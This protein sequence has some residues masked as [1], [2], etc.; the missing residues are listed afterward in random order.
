MVAL[1]ISPPRSKFRLAIAVAVL[2]ICAITTASGQT[3]NTVPDAQK[4]PAAQSA[5]A[6]SDQVFDS[7]YRRFYDTYRLGPADEIS[8]R[9]KG[10]PEYSTEKTKISPTGTVYHAL[11]GE[12]SVAGLTI[13]QVTER[14]TNDLSEY[15]KNPQVSVQLI[16]AASAKIGVLGDVVR[17]GIIV[18]ARPMSVIDAI[19]EAGGFAETGS[20]S[21]VEV[22]RQL[23][24]GTRTA[25]KV[26]VKNILEGKAKP[27]ENVQLQAGDLVY[28]HGNT[29]KAILKVTSLAGFGNFLS[30]ITLGR[31]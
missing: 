8:I 24:D 20:K 18:M 30:F 9:I 16:E 2:C 22:N 19:S 13:P 25:I 4:E 15:L 17:P 10:Q 26:N 29:T 27:G 14:L 28:V 31:R 23:P 1:K 5:A 3:A 11:L 6:K 12:V 7:I 21:S